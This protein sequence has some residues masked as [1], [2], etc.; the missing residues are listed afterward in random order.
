[1]PFVSTKTKI[2]NKIYKIFRMKL[3]CYEQNQLQH[4]KQIATCNSIII[5]IIVISNDMI[6]LNGFITMINP[7]YDKIYK[8]NH[9]IKLKYKIFGNNKAHKLS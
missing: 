2:A 4:E 1:M 9:N 5:I 3:T 8:H 6:Y 7:F